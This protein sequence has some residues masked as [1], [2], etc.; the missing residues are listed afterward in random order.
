MSTKPA[1]GQCIETAPKKAVPSSQ[2]TTTASGGG[3]HIITPVSFAATALT[4]IV[5]PTLYFV[6]KRLVEMQDQSG[7]QNSAES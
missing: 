5:I 1:A 3:V 4:L 2:G 6:I 7:A